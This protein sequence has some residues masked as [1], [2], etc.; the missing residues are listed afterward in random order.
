M[1]LELQE[2]EAHRTSKHSAH[3]GGK[4]TSPTHRPHLTSGETLGTHFCYRMSRT[5]GLTEDG[6]IKPNDHFGNRA[7]DL[8][9]C[10][11]ASEPTVPPH[12]IS[13]SSQRTQEHILLLPL[14]T[15]GR[16]PPGIRLS[17]RDSDNSASM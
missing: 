2:V 11:A 15:S 5:D 10:S 16:V 4:V 12:M 17:K 3:E 14:N 13:G 8:P 1:P 6:R 7:R 9:S